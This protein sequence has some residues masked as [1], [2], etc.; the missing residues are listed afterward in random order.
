MKNRSDIVEEHEKASTRKADVQRLITF[1]LGALFYKN[2]NLI[3]RIY[4]PWKE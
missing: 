4:E 1:S 3:L 2:S